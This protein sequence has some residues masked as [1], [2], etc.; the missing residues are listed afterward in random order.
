MLWARQI[1][2]RVIDGYQEIGWLPAKSSGEW[3]L[4][5]VFNDVVVPGARIPGEKS[6]HCRRDIRFSL[7]VWWCW[8]Q[9]APS[10]KALMGISSTEIRVNAGFCGL[11]RRRSGGSISNSQ[12]ITRSY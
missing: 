10:L 5:Q 6:R 8:T 12:K 7:S 3:G 1:Q 9:F 4:A 11:F 2:N